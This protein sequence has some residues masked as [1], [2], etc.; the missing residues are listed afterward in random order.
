[1]SLLSGTARIYDVTGTGA[2]MDAIALGDHQDIGR[3]DAEAEIP[4]LWPPDAKN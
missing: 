3:T 4:V 1:M 2:S